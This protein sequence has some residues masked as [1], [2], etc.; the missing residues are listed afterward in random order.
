[1]GSIIRTP[2]FMIPVVGVGVVFI[3]LPLLAAS[4]I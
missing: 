2:S 3:G 1:M 4:D